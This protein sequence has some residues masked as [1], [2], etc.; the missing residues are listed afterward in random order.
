[1]SSDSIGIVLK[2]H[3]L[4]ACF[5]HDARDMGAFHFDLFVSIVFSF[6]VVE[7]MKHIFLISAPI[8]FRETAGTGRIISLHGHRECRG[9][10]ASI[11]RR[12]KYAENLLSK[13]QKKIMIYWIPHFN[14]SQFI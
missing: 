14:I 7:T 8:Y 6:R 9:Q 13:Q 1:M 5:L 4:P 10:Q 2:L 3:V 11:F 12:G